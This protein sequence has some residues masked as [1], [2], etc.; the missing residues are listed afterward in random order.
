MKTI[1]LFAYD[2]PHRKT[3]D[4]ILE[5]VAAG[6]KRVVVLAAG[7]K[8]LKHSD[9][10]IYFS[11]S[12]HP[13]D[14]ISPAVLCNQLGLPYFAVEHDDV[15]R[16]AKI[17]DQFSCRLAIISGARILSAELLSLFPEGVINFHP[18]R[19]PETSGLDAFYYTIKFNTLP[20][21]TAHFIDSRVDAGAEILFEECKLTPFCTPEVLVHNIYQ[22]QISVLRQIL[23]RISEKE[24]CSVAVDR[25][26]KNRPMDFK[27][28]VEILQKFPSWTVE[29]YL[30]QQY[31]KLLS[32]IRS[33]ELECADR[34]MQHHPSLLHRR[35]K[36]S[37]TPIIIAAH[38]GSLPM[39]K[40]L[41]KHGANP[42]DAGARGTTVL[43]YAKTAAL[44]TDSGEY[45]LLE[46]LMSVGAA[47]ERTDALGKTVADYCL[48]AGDYKLHAYFK[49]SMP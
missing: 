13:A 3:N 24:L 15:E 17:L 21:V 44:H 33:E 37:W 42:N 46:Y 38:H 47:P 5:M 11:T 31:N 28:K 7:R 12:L 20:G 10:N 40:L 27:E 48:E 1:A 29:Q 16:I 30:V 43:M 45:P 26:T 22:L 9:N 35:S 2:F 49:S 32:H 39:V 36:E 18:G 34:I 19:I 4:F 14:P 23:R 41:I 25:P 8:V 6:F